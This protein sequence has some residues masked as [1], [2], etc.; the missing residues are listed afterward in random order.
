M[1]Y[2]I[3]AKCDKDTF[4]NITESSLECKYK[5]GYNYLIEPIRNQD[6]IIEYLK[7]VGYELKNDGARKTSLGHKPFKKYEEWK[8]GPQYV[9]LG[10]LKEIDELGPKLEDL[11]DKNHL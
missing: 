1:N 8:K 3:K 6:Q 2:T 5:N 11:Y 9:V 10:I 7:T 4:L